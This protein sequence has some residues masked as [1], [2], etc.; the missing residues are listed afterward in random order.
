[1]ADK[2][3]DGL[4]T[5]EAQV[6]T[7]EEAPAEPAA[8]S[9]EKP[10]DDAAKKPYRQG[11]INRK[12]K[13][14]C[15]FCADKT[16]VIDYKEPNKLRRFTSDHGKILPRRITGTCAMHQ[17]EVTRAIKLARVLALLP[18]TQD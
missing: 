17:R 2:S 18:Y 10:A 11:N 6:E 12:K 8:K 4:N 5:F 3:M 15:L 13:K 9:E 7:K 16:A 14:V 1:M